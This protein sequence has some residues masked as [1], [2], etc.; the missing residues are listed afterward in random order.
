MAYRLAGLTVEPLYYLLAFANSSRYT[1]LE[2]RRLKHLI[3][4]HFVLGL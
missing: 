3:G 1:F 2:C 4:R